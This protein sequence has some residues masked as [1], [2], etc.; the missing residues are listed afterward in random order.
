MTMAKPQ[1]IDKRLNAT[2]QQVL[3]DRQRQIAG[4]LS[5]LIASDAQR[6][7]ASRE[8]TLSGELRRAV[9]SSGLS[10]D[11]LANRCG[12][13]AATL[14][15]FLTGETTLPSDVIDRLADVLGCRLAQADRS[16][17]EKSG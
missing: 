7:H 10:L 4:E 14:D 15:R 5:D 3:E 11:Q 6:H 2:E 8:P 9:H 13:A 12:I 1:R 17:P 16:V